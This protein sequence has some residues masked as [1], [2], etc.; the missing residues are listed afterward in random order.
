M[1]INE[2]GNKKQSDCMTSEKR[3]PSVW[4]LEPLFTEQLRG[5]VPERRGLKPTYKHK[6]VVLPN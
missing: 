6:T 3:I 1:F 2:N 4:L 5:V